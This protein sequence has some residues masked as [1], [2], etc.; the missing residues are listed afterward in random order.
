MYIDLHCYVP[1]LADTLFEC[2]CARSNPDPRQN[3]KESFVSLAISLV[4]LG[5]NTTR[6]PLSVSR[7][8][9]LHYFVLVCSKTWM[10]LACCHCQLT[11]S[12]LIMIVSIDGSRSLRG[13]KA[14]FLNHAAAAEQPVI[15]A[16]WRRQWEV[17]AS[18]FGT[19]LKKE[20][21]Y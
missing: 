12:H 17:R 10:R 18:N 4:Y 7:I 8:I 9:D 13:C 3:S 1:Q 16:H 2:L 21:A 6:N 5:A 14:V 20:H 19:F 11:F 15:V